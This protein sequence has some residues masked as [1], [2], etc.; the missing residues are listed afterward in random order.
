MRTWDGIR[1]D[2]TDVGGEHLLAAV[3]ASWAVE[4]QIQRR[5]GLSRLVNV[6]GISIGS[7]YADPDGTYLVMV[8]SSGN[9]Q[10]TLLGSPSA[11]DVGDVKTTFVP[12]F[13]AS[14]PR[15]YV[16]DD[17]NRLQTWNGIW[18]A[19]RD[20]GIA[21]PTTVMPSPSSTDSGD[22]TEGV[23]LI[24]YRYVD[25]QSPQG[26]YRSNPSEALS[27]TVTSSN[28]ELTFTINDTGTSG[29]KRSADSKVD[30]IVVEMTTA[31]GTTYYEAATV[32][33]SETSV[34]VNL[35]D[36]TLQNN[37]LATSFGGEFG[38]EQPP[39]TA[40]AFEC[41]DI[42]FA[43]GFH[44]WTVTGDVTNGSDSISVTAGNLSE[45]WDGRLVRV[46]SD[47]TTYLI[48]A[49][50]GST[51][52]LS[53]NY[54]GSDA[55]GATIQILPAQPNLVYHSERYYPESFKLAS[56]GFTA[57]VG[58]GDRLVGGTNYLGDAWFFGR[59]SI[60]RMVF[61]DNPSTG[62]PVTV[63]GQAGIW[64]QRCLVLPDE[65]TMFGFGSN[66]VWMVVGGRPKHISR[67]IDASWRS[68]VDYSKSDLFHAVY[69]P[70]TRTAHFW[71]VRTGDSYPKDAVVVDLNRR[72]VRLDQWRQP[73][74]S[75]HIIANDDGRIRPIVS[76]QNGYTWYM[77]GATDGVPS[78]STGKYTADAGNSTTVT[79]V[80]DSLPTGSDDLK[81]VTL[82]RPATS[83]AVL[84]AS[85]GASS[86]T[87]AAFAT[88]VAAG[89][90]LY[91][92]SIPFTLD[93]SWWV[94]D[95][96]QRKKRPDYFYIMVQP[97]STGSL[98]VYLYRDFQSSPHTWTKATSQTGT[99]GVT[100]NNGE[101]YCTVD[102]STTGTDGLVSVPVP[103]NWSRAVKAKIEVVDP[104]GTIRIL[105][106]RWGL[107]DSRDLMEGGGE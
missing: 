69:D 2:L 81:G 77:E 84:I 88:A 39:A 45:L 104:S 95:D 33:N 29:I 32:A 58:T 6:G 51:I 63:A 61:I 24:R 67:S 85:N 28:E 72:R 38:H 105:D 20:A 55:T 70:N 44:T 71:F 82:V 37:D 96:L 3:G 62:E 27:Y 21:A 59:R 42:L 80:T 4:G 30:T 14:S 91:A 11:S 5:P 23:H 103:A 98:R 41:R 50:S 99:R 57:L 36:T 60:Q 53:S 92:G 74:R 22:T 12:N 102:V 68:I 93:T 100:W 79:N 46:G 94:H 89:E 47:T 52:T 49:I 87:H 40:F 7:F 8:D 65:D 17:F 48:E 64:N 78:S 34:V 83:E 25:S 18:S 15:M 35:S 16:A 13:I 19:F 1:A 31:G 106:Y 73:I 97:G 90:T 101:T 56:R 26:R 86:I 76:D 10:A 43:G 107:S 66:G 54:D 75:S 9:L